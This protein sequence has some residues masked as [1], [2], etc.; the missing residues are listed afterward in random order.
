MI[1]ILDPPSKIRFCI[2]EVCNLKCRFCTCNKRGFKNRLMDFDVYRSLVDKVV[3]YSPNAF[4][5]LIG[6]GEP[7]MHPQCVDIIHYAMQQNAK[8][9]SLTSNG[10]LLIE[11]IQKGLLK[12]KKKLG[13]SFSVDGMKESYEK[14]RVGSN[15]EKVVDNICN[16]IKMRNRLKKYNIQISVNMTKVKHSDE[17]L[18]EYIYFWIKKGVDQIIIRSLFE[19]NEHTNITRWVQPEALPSFPYKKPCQFLYSFL[20]F[21]YT[22]KVEHLCF[23]PYGYHKIINFNTASESIK[24]IW[25]SE[26]YENLRKY[27]II[28]VERY[29][30][31]CKNC[32]IWKIDYL[33]IDREIIYI[34]GKRCLGL[35]NAYLNVYK[36]AK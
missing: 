2:S 22:G 23:G 8:A 3:S 13:I 21:E 14:I 1:D 4:L 26:V 30:P 17:E 16:F 36:V 24:D 15:F 29:S 18:K 35:K 5:S 12:G 28:D 7:L 32:E 33:P 9:I 25:H 10:T 11:N 34:N 6:K 31:L 19:I 27:H 20:Q